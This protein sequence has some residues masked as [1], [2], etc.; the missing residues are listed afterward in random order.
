MLVP[1]HTSFIHGSYIISTYLHIKR[2]IL[3]KPQDERP[4]FIVPLHHVFGNKTNHHNVL[5]GIIKT[6]I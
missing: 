5:M 3:I 6:G 4:F 1:F 2:W